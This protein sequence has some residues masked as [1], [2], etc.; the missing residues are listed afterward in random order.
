M[1][2]VVPIIEG[3]KVD[4]ISPIIDRP[5]GFLGQC[6]DNRYYDSPQQ[7]QFDNPIAQ[8]SH[9]FHMTAA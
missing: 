5:I 9:Y 2:F 1:L 6:S 8:N 7:G 3:P 4:F